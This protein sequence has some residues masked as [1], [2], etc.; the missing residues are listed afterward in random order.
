MHLLPM[1][2]SS[3]IRQR[4]TKEEPCKEM[5][6]LPVFDP[7]EYVSW[8][9]D[10]TLVTEFKETLSSQPE[11]FAIVESL[12]RQAK[13][14]LYSGMLRTRLHDTRDAVADSLISVWIDSDSCLRHFEHFLAYLR[15]D[16]QVG[17][18]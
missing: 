3:D 1:Y 13:L 11:R 18:D 5:K 8:K 10:P 2:R 4:A 6:R 14:E 15:V 12:G 7:A 9:P 17:N 16:H